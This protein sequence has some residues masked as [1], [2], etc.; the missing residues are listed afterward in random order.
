[1]SA[2]RNAAGETAQQIHDRIYTE[3]YVRV[4]SDPASTNQQIEEASAHIEDEEDLLIALEYQLSRPVQLPK[5]EPG[6]QRVKVGSNRR[7]IGLG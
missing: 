5:L 6:K 7:R 4:M 2:P 3:E 1:M